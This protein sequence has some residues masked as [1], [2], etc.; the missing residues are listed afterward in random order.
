MADEIM[1]DSKKPSP[2]ASLVRPEKPLTPE[3]AAPV[4]AAPEKEKRPKTMILARELAD[5]YYKSMEA[6]LNGEVHHM[7][8]PFAALDKTIPAWL[9][10][11]HLIVVAGRP[12]MGKTVFG[13]MIG[14]HVAEKGKTAI[15]FTLEMSNYEVTER[16]ISRRSGVPIP[17]LKMVDEL[18]DDD[19]H[20][21]SEALGAF[22]VLPLLVDDCSFD[23]TTIVAKTKAVSLGLAKKGLPPLGCVVV[24]YLQ[25]IAGKGANKTIEIG[26]V[27]GALKRM[28][29]ELKIPVIALSQLNRAVEGRVEKRPQMSDL[30]ESGNIEQDADLIL[31][32]YRDEYY[33]KEAC[34]EPGVAEVN[35][36]KNRHGG[37]GVAKLAFIG[38][39][40]M[41]ANLATDHPHPTNGAIRLPGRA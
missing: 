19:W 9:H 16:S 28:A 31:L 2:W 25:L 5:I 13:Q 8:G 7:P 1:T 32:L 12:A 23:I 29:G 21:I 33:S 6:L 14:E 15:I 3:S 37:T 41:F 18:D 38:E 24:D 36:V 20:G 11:G 30:R 10:E 40:V 35:A 17:K 22:E 26:Q 27:S 39:R 4:A 34:Q